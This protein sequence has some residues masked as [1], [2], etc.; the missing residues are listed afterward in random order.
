LDCDK[1]DVGFF[2]TFQMTTNLWFQHGESIKGIQPTPECNDIDDLITLIHEKPAIK[3]QL[4]IPK[5]CG[6]I[7]LFHNGEK[8]QPT[9]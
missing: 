9:L 7:T 5:D 4:Q 3:K 8:L 6:T 2:S 1:N